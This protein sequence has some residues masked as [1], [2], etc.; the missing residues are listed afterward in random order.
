MIVVAID[1]MFLVIMTPGSFVLPGVSTFLIV[2]RSQV[3]M[4]LHRD[5]MSHRALN[6]WRNFLHYLIP[7]ILGAFY[8]NEKIILF[9]VIEQAI[10]Q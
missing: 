8:N 4:P 10:S 5:V 6:N 1:C 2:D 7:P 9:I 3:Q